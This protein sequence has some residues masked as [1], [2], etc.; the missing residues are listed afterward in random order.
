M[1]TLRRCS[2]N[3]AVACDA[4]VSLLTIEEKGE[5]QTEREILRQVK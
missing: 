2:A 1:G 3:R 5:T 4:R